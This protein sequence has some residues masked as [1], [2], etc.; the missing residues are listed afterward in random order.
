MKKVAIYTTPSCKYC[1]AVKEFFKE[2]NVSYEEYNVASDEKRRDEM[3]ELSGQMGV[4]VITIDNDL[5]IGFNKPVLSE[6]L[7]VK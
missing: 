3:I 2:N 1:G 5:V 7:E 4:P 6:L